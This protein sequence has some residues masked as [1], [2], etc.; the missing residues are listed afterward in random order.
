MLALRQLLPS[1]TADI[2]AAFALLGWNKPAS[3][4]ERYL[5]E[6]AL[7]IRTTIIARLD[8]A[9]AGYVTIKW[10]SDYPVFRDAT[11]PEVQDLNVL[12]DFRRRHIGSRLMDEA[13]KMIVARSRVAELGVGFDPEYG[14]AQRLY[15]LRGYVPDGK[16][17]T[18][19]DVRVKW[20][21]SV[22]V[23]DGLVLYFT[24]TLDFTK[25]GS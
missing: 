14:A 18:S 22:R 12:P 10:N 6:A 23:D 20:G 17:G 1:D 9:F 21:D 8:R 11:V 2:S 4:Y 15:V 5:D 13:E 24:K 7:G 16:G 25:P 19:H 3:Q